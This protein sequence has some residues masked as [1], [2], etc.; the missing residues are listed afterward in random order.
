MKLLS[1]I[2]IGI[3]L[4]LFRWIF[5]IDLTIWTV[6]AGRATAIPSLQVGDPREHHVAGGWIHIA[7]LA[8]RAGGRV[9]VRDPPV[10]GR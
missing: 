8:G 5:N 1:N 7:Q 6:S 4:L 2:K 9:Q 10:R 3:E